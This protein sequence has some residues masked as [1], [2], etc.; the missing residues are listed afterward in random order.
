MVI[1]NVKKYCNFL[2][3]FL[4]VSELVNRKHICAVTAQ[5]KRTLEAADYSRYNEGLIGDIH[6]NKKSDVFFYLG[7]QRLQLVRIY[8]KIMWL[9]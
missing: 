4:C 7:N 5:E 8:K 3:T 6:L 2:C 9:K 1:N